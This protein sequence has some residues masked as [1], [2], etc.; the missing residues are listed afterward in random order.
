MAER[1]LDVQ[2]CIERTIGKQWPQKYGIVL[3]R[4]QWG[5][6]EATERSIDAAPQAVRMTDLRCRRQLSLTGEPRP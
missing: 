3:A 4:N 2:R 5:A 6:I 1:Y